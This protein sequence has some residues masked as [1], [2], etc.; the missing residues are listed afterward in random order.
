MPSQRDG[1]GGAP[2]RLLDLFLCHG[3]LQ[4]C[5]GLWPVAPSPV[6]RSYLGAFP[7]CREYLPAVLPVQSLWKSAWRNTEQRPVS[8]ISISR[9]LT[10]R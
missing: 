1:I 4:C 9:D 10:F 6:R 3:V 8:F 5:S 2:E 7:V